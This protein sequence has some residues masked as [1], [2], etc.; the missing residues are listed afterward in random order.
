MTSYSQNETGESFLVDNIEVFKTNS[1]QN[2]STVPASRDT[3]TDNMSIAVNNGQGRGTRLCTAVC[4][5]P[6]NQPQRSPQ[7]PGSG[8][9][10]NK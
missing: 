8:P 10:G 4:V 2:A 5:R 1:L 9:V 3:V 6:P 7:G